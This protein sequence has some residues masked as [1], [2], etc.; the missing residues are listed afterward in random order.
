MKNHLRE[1]TSCKFPAILGLHPDRESFAFTVMNPEET[2]CLGCVYIF[3]VDATMFA[4]AQISSLDGALWQDFSAAVYFWI[5][6]SEL[7]DALDR[8]L[9]AALIPWLNRDWHFGNPLFVT[10]EQFGQQVAMVEN[11]GLPLRFRIDDPKATGSFLGY[12]TNRPNP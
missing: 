3:P 2:R 6:K 7:A 9:L 5:R 4:R 8:R 11:A 1:C 10:N 12:G